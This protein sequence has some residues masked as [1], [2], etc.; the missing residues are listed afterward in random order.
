METKEIILQKTFELLLCKGYNGVAVSDIQQATGMA[1]GLLYHYFGSVDGLFRIVIEKYMRWWMT[2][3]G[4]EIK[5]EAVSR[6]INFV[7]EHYRG[8][9][10][11]IADHYGD[12]FSLTDVELLFREA[13]RHQEELLEVYLKMR[14]EQYAWWKTAL[15]NSFSLGEL[16]SG[17]NL[18][19]V[20]QH[21]IYLTD[22]M[23]L[24]VLSDTLFSEHIYALEKRLRAY[25]EII[26]R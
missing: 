8:K 21:F 17:L 19:S 12:R 3:E 9:S 10:Q 6:F 14:A 26:C 24:E 23:L 13:S 11:E 4:E 1:R 7:V 20:A 18:E 16:R 5:S 15:L 25:V 2:Y 22:G